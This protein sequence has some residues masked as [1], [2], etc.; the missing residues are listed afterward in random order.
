LAEVYLAS[1]GLNAPGSHALRFHPGLKDKDSGMRWPAMVALVTR[2]ND[3]LPMSI[4]RTFLAR[5][6]KGKAPLEQPRQNLGPC[7]GN[8]IRLAEPTASGLLLVGEGIETCLAA[9]QATGIPAWAAGS[10]P[11]LGAMI[12]PRQVRDVIVLVDGDRAGHEAANL[13]RAWHRRQGRRVRLA[14]A[15]DG[16]DFNDIPPVEARQLV[17][18]AT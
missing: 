16:M 11:F 8:S 1:R 2:G 15:P 3:G 10:A 14:C 5:D 18:R 4:H 13:F 7:K 9:M 12:L 17:E 6:G